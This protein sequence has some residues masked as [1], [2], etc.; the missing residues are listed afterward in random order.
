M[1][2]W[3]AVSKRLDSAGVNVDAGGT[4]RRRNNIPDNS[5]VG[6]SPAGK[7][8]RRKLKRKPQQSK[9]PPCSTNAFG[10][11]LVFLH[12]TQTVSKTVL[13]VF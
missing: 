5:N 3:P 9:Q 11:Q 1:T 6:V 4:K 10:N 12:I 7:I 13:F 2:K 8:L